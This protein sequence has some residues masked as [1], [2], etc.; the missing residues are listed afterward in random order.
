MGIPIE[1]YDDFVEKI[2]KEY[3]E[4][5]SYCKSYRYVCSMNMYMF[6][7]HTT[8]SPN[9]FFFLKLFLEFMEEKNIK[10]KKLELFFFKKE[11]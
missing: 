1:E 8:F 7:L 9:I 10:K 4:N 11:L 2:K 5:K 3:D 6:H